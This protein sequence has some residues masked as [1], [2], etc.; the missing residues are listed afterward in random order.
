[1]LF[2]LFFQ[3][4]FD[5]VHLQIQLSLQPSYNYFINMNTVLRFVACLFLL[6][7]LTAFAQ[8]T[9][10][11]TIAP[12]PS[13][14]PA[15]NVSTDSVLV[16]LILKHQ[17]DKNLLEIRRK[18]EA[19]GFW[20]L[21]PPKEVKIESWQIVMG[22]GH[23]IVLKTPANAIRKLNLAIENGA[24]GAYSSEIYLTYDYL[25]VWEEYTNRRAEY[26]KDK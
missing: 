19:N 15:P 12:G 13:L 20:D 25:P 24:W 11:D 16:T 14:Q 22:L 8:N 23:I 2:F 4:I 10:A 21:F 17:Q 9:A 7:P 5:S 1:M 18:L 26:L 3:P 6:L